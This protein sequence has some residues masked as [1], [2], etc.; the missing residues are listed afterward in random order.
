VQTQAQTHGPKAG[1]A[2]H[3]QLGVLLSAQHV[4]LLAQRQDGLADLAGLLVGA[5]CRLLGLQPRNAL[6]AL[7]DLLGQ[8]GRRA[9]LVALLVVDLELHLQGEPQAATHIG[10]RRSNTHAQ[11]MLP[12]LGQRRGHGTGAHRTHTT[13]RVS[14]LG[15]G[16]GVGDDVNPT[17]ATD[18]DVQSVQNVGHTLHVIELDVDD[19]T[20]H[21]GAKEGAEGHMRVSRAAGKLQRWEGCAR[22]RARGRPQKRCPA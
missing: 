13:Q 5:E 12:E 11:N 9:D 4:V 16:G 18:L 2:P 8:Q 14:E 3:L 15:G 17:R 19:G 20:H 7:A 21:L 22:K 10:E 6:V 1:A